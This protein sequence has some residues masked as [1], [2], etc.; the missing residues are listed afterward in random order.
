M[1]D[2][3][4]PRSGRQDFR[5]RT[6][7]LR[8]WVGL[9]I[10][11]T[12]TPTDGLRF[13]NLHRSRCWVS[14]S[15][16]LARGAGGNALPPRRDSS[17]QLCGAVVRRPYCVRLF[18]VRPIT[19]RI[20]QTRPMCNRGHRFV[21]RQIAHLWNDIANRRRDVRI[22]FVDRVEVLDDVRVREPALEHADLDLVSLRRRERHELRREAA[23]FR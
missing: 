15:P 1:S 4:C 11:R 7:G 5:V 3:P 18:S 13:Q 19:R 8:R 2:H 14:A 17:T 9:D 12:L 16:G 21:Y 23:S 20:C 10:T 22:Q 6:G